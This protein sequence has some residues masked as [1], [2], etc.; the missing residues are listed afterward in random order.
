MIHIEDAHLSRH[1][2]GRVLLVGRA[3]RRDGATLRPD[4]PGI[5]ASAQA[6]VP[7]VVRTLTL[8]VAIIVVTFVATGLGTTSLAAHQVAFTLWT[9]YQR[10][11]TGE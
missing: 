6:G 11:R 9:I 10:L 4:R 8:R 1:R 5:I 2:R 3:A 7:L